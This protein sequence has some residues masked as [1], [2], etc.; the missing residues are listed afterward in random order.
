MWTGLVVRARTVLD[1][2]SSEKEVSKSG[3]RM[4]VKEEA[5][6]EGDVQAPPLVRV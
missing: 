2:S 3:K 5:N 4:P 6:E 1:F